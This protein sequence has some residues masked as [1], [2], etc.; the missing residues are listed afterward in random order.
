FETDDSSFIASVTFGLPL[1]R[2][3]ERLDVRRAQINLERATRDFSLFRDTVAV[4]A[5]ASVRN[6]DRAR[7]SVTL[8]DQ[9]RI[10]AQRRVDV[11]AAAPDRATA[12]ERSDA[13][14]GLNRA[15]DAYDRAVRDLQVGILQ[16]LLD[17]GRMRVQSDGSIRPLRGITQG[18]ANDPDN[19]PV[20]VGEPAG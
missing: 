16:Y 3:I 10:I 4:E 5:R 12:L 15:R 19:A 11:I 13:I 2:E 7:F 9:N 6:V 18:E 17:T 14:E 1:D 8:Q 20:P